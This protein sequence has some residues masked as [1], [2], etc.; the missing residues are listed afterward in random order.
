MS[1]LYAKSH[2]VSTSE[3]WGGENPGRHSYSSVLPDT[4]VEPSACCPP[5][6][7]PCDCEMR[8]EANL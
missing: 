3:I 6:K 2:Y 8:T 1:H 4:S 5:K 7:L